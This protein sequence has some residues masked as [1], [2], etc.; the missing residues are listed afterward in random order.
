[1]R[2]LPDENISGPEKCITDSLLETDAVTF[3]MQAALVRKNSG[4]VR[5][6][7]EP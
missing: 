1:M 3:I 2:K 5:E 4:R 6:E 7:E